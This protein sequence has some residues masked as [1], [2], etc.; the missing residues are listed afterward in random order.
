M[1][2][3]RFCGNHNKN[4]NIPSIVA[5]ALELYPVN[6]DVLI[7]RISDRYILHANRNGTNTSEEVQR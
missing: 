1:R 6:F 2:L 7:L 5:L 4:I 3:N